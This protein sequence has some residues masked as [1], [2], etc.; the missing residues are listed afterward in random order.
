MTRRDFLSSAAAFAAVP[1]FAKKPEE[2]RESIEK[3]GNM[4]GLKAQL[5]SEKALKLVIDESK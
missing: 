1:A 4:D 2:I 3:A 5:R